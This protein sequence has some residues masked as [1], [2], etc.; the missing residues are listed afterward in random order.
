MG[1]TEQIPEGC[2][3]VVE[4]RILKL[5]L[6]PGGLK[7]E[8][9]GAL[10]EIEVAYEMCGTLAPDCSNVVFVCHALT[11]DAHV[12]GLRPGETKP[13]GWWEGM[14]GYG[15]GIDTNHYCVI[16]ANLLSG[17]KGTTGPSSINPE[18]GHPYGSS[19]PEITVGDIVDVER[20]LLQQLG[21]QRLAAV[22]GGSFGGM[23]ALEWA[24]RYPDLLDNCIVIAS[25]ASLNPQAL[26]FDIIGRE[27]ITQDPNWQNGDYYESGRSPTLGLSRARKLAH[28][29]YLSLELMEDKFGRERRPDWVHAPADF[30]E[31]ARR[32]FHTTFQVESY[33]A[34][35]GDKFV[36]RFDANSYLHITRALDEYD[37]AERFGS[38]E[39]AFERVKAKMLIVALS[40]DWL[41]HPEQSEDIVRALVACR[42]DVSYCHLQAMA[43]HDAFIT[44]ISEL[45]RVVRAFLPWVG[46]YAESAQTEAVPPERKSVME[47]VPPH[48]RVLDLGCGDCSLLRQLIA[49]KHI[50]GTGVEIDLEKVIDAIDSGSEVLRQDVDDGLATIPDDSFDIC[51]LSETLQAMKRPLD[52]LRQILRVARTAVIA[53][54]NF[55]YLPVRAYLFFRGRMPM[56]KH[57]PFAWYNTPNIHLFTL[58]DFMELCEKEGI[59][60]L[61]RRFVSYSAL[62]RAMISIGAPNFGAEHIIVKIGRQ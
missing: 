27:A 6:P 25:A 15:R 16:C 3:G 24:I 37:L 11:G 19:F 43:G 41:F 20:L 32:E 48:S 50:T 5:Q 52:V 55:A 39:K 40:G 26:A 57:L 28:V 53:F 7:L 45:K 46:T 35:Q 33:L 10:S 49:E 9:G 38:L 31:K 56:S 2:V 14:V 58:H 4:Q 8:K 30:R 62:G 22:I 36:N 44:H 12:A 47:M 1:Q 18:T 60:V 34:H 54:P 51:V 13:S 59:R 17:C 29:T 61:E 21:I 42:K 23:Q